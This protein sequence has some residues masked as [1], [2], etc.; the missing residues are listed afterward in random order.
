MEIVG[1]K[2][3]CSFTIDNQLIEWFK[4]YAKDE[5]TTMSAVLNQYILSL[6]RGGSKPKNVLYT[7]R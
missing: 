4:L 2:K 7:N 5:S 1:M 6:K 3:K